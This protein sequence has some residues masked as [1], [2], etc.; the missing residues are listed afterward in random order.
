[1]PATFSFAPKNS[2]DALLPQLFS[3]LRANMTAI[4]PTGDSYEEDLAL[5]KAY[6]LPA[7][8]DKDRQLVLLHWEGHLAGYFQ[9]AVHGDTLMMEEIQIKPEYQGTG[10]FRSLYQWLAKELPAGLARAEAYAHKSNQ[11]SQAIL[12]HLGLKKAGENPSGSSWRYQGDCQA[13]WKVLL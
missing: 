12:E 2:L 8:G 10:L 11:K 1:M 3:I 6:I 9:Y 4:A 7:L 13:M 5:W